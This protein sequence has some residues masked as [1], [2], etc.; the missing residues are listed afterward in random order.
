MPAG[1]SF[2]TAEGRIRVVG[3]NDMREIL[4]PLATRFSEAHP[5][6]TFEFDLRGTRYAPEALAS[7][8]SAFAPMG[9]VFT[10]GQLAGYRRQQAQ[11]PA[12]F[13]LAHVSPDPAA[14]SGPLAVF[15][16]EE[17]PL[18]SLTLEQLR[19]IFAGAMT[20]WGELGLVG[21]WERRTITV[22]GM[23]DGTALRHEFSSLV[24]GG[25]EMT[26][27]MTGLAQ[28]ADVVA[29]VASDPGGIGFAAA[30]RGRPGARVVAL[31][32]R[33]EDPPVLPTPA[34]LMGN[35]YPL[36]RFLYL[37]AARPVPG[38][39][40]EFVRLALSR[41]GQSIVAATPQRYIP[42]S[43]ADAEAERD[44]L[45]QF[46]LESSSVASTADSGK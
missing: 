24:M 35:R 26:P 11:D 18:A 27:A 6:I 23:R 4:E 5:A 25:R 16:N 13:R 12:C 14:L 28:S 20:D 45:A 3:Y 39:A 9:A 44:R 30:M 43:D 21:P 7:G 22:Y 33:P 15:V 36:D 40:L 38:V 34:D 42:L 8:T 19:R 32:P 37:C 1:A 29:R 31:R 46:S 17:N 2:V 41:E 10:P